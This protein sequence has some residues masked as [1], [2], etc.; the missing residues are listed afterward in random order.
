MKDKTAGEPKER[1]DKNS[2]FPGPFIRALRVFL[3]I[4]LILCALVFLY[5]LY[6]RSHYKIVYYHE[7]SPKVAGSMRIAVIS[8]IH[9]REYG[10]ENETLISDL[11]A[12][13]PDLILFP[14]DMV[15]RPP[16]D[17]I[18]R[19][20]EDCRAALQLISASREI[21]P[22][23]GVLGNHE[24]ERIYY[25]DDRALPEK[26][27]KAGLRLL[28]NA[29]VKIRIGGNRVRL[30]GVEGTAYGFEEYGGREF[31]EN[32]EIDP[33]A[34]CILMTHIPILF[35]KL[36]VYGFDLGV[37]GHVHG[38]IVKLPFFGGLYS[39]EEGFFPKYDA[40]KFILNNGQTLIVSAGLGDSK[41]FPPRINNT[42]EL[43]VIDINR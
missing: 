40:G 12:L 2:S 39:H 15:V 22:C 41:I 19:E 42:P 32:T 26:L 27:E 34:F 14:G 3:I 9:N 29:S 28:R 43:T 1:A 18:A 38:G 7:T 30:I 36:S 24:S 21:A 37:A 8:D 16:G 23:Y 25:K 31:M 35:D 13:K 10:E 5:A 33:S 6:T 11:R 17:M 20:E 4:T